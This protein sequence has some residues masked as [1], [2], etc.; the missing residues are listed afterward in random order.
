MTAVSGADPLR[1]E[2]APFVRSLASQRHELHLLLEGVN[3]GACV[4]RIER[5]LRRL[6]TVEEARVNLTLRR[7]YL[8]WRGD[9]EQ[10]SELVA[11]VRALGY[12]AVPFDPER[13]QSEA[14]ERERELLRA[15]AVAGFAAGN[16]MLLAVSVWAGHAY[17]MGEATRAFFHW[18]EAFIAL[19]AIAYA[20]RPFFRS[21][22]TALRSG[23]TNLD[24]PIS[25]AVLLAPALSLYETVRGGEHVYFDSAVTLLF[26][27]LIGRY[28]DQR[29]RGAARSAAER[30]LALRTRPVTLLCDDGTTRSVRPDHLRPGQ[31]ILVAP[32]ER[33]GADGVVERGRSAVDRSAISGESVPEPVAEGAQVFAGTLNLEAPL[34]VRVRAVGED[35]LLADMTRLMALAEQR[36]GRFVAL[37][38]RLARLY[39]P[40]VHSL[41]LLTFLGW[42][43]VGESDWQ[44]ALL[45]ATAVLIITCPCALAL[46]VPAVQ[47]IA[48]GRL[49]RQGILLKSA[50]A[51]ERFAEVDVVA[52]DKTGTL[53]EDRPKPQLAGLDRRL[54][55]EAAAL[56]KA[57]RH[58]LARALADALPDVPV[59]E[60]VVEVPGSGLVW[61][62]PDGEWRLG[63]RGF[64]GPEG[65]GVPQGPEL[66]FS[67]PGAAPLCIRFR[68][69][70]RPD[71]RA[72][73]ERLRGSGYELMVLSGDR[74][75]VVERVAREVGIR[76]WQA[77]LRPDAKVRALE[78]LRERGRKVLMVGDGLN[79][80][81]ALAAAHVSLSPAHAMDIS[82]TA[83]DAVFQGARL[84]P[85]CEVLEVARRAQRLVRQNI[86]FA[87]LYN[88]IAI[89]FAMAGFVTPLVA[90]LAMS[91]S[92]ITVVLNALRLDG[93]PLFGLGEPRRQ[94]MR[95][96]TERGEGCRCAALPS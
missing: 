66:W 84:A 30:L 96:R 67:R 79:D 12:G 77:E 10:A 69:R 4:Q 5:A 19:P 32:G 70:L 31:R 86:A 39:A 47:V 23:H 62:G 33:I 37:A 73:I 21:A 91:S 27:L 65:D 57:S 87:L 48:C 95:E 83:A 78:A 56:A 29:A 36:R 14:E 44:E 6:P 61:R 16:V 25:L 60:D 42:W 55:R 76:D 20:G 72:V 94:A 75:P 89:P 34:R 45:Y 43:L 11:R 49:M 28:L 74:A 88:T 53:T 17:G 82:Q 85:V 3:C 8:R 81:P 52:L 7:L 2:L 46:A 68:D 80:A 18:F 41:A 38:D 9:R 71:A 24:V 26:F 35:T 92:S 13:M 93:G 22:W 63:R 40:L 58:P 54:L 50:T 15:M 51:L 90:A 64:A 1:A 59:R